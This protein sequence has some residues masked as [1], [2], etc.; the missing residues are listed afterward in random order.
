MQ[1]TALRSQLRTN[2]PGH[3][4]VVGEVTFSSGV[5]AVA[6]GT[7]FTVGRGV[8]SLT[9][10]SSPTIAGAP[11]GT[12]T[13]VPVTTAS[14]ST[15]F[16]SL[17]TTSAVVTAATVTAPGYDYTAA[18]TMSVAV[19]SLFWTASSLA[20]TTATAGTYYVSLPINSGTGMVAKVVTS[21]TAITAVTVNKALDAN[22]SVG[23]N[24]GTSALTV[25]LPENALYAGSPAVSS[26][27]TLTPNPALTV[28]TITTVITGNCSV[29]FANKVQ[30]VIAAMATP[31]STVGNTAFSIVKRFDGPA[32]VNFATATYVGAG[33]T[34]SLTWLSATPT[35]GDGFGFEIVATDTAVTA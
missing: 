25:D 35:D 33:P 18:A 15:A 30:S 34:A 4:A 26:A 12:Y 23:V 31:M 16:C 6:T 1:G 20:S 19:G 8:L 21:G 11:N 27:F 22:T 9:L 14:G 32:Y 2:V 3:T 24:Y 7:R 10:A 13:N 17:T 29:V 5:P 28:G